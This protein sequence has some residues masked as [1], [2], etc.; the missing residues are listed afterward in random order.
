MLTVL[1]AFAAITYMPV[2]GPALALSCTSVFRCLRQ[3]LQTSPSSG[4]EGGDSMAVA[5]PPGLA[6]AAS[7]VVVN[8]VGGVGDWTIG[9]S[10]EYIVATVAVGRMFLPREMRVPLR[11]TFPIV[12]HGPCMARSMV[13]LRSVAVTLPVA[14][15]CPCSEGKWSI[16]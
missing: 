8:L 9:T 6:D 1:V 16:W 15:A 3:T 7:V 2:T 14:D 5:G 12:G 13:V 11:N 4:G 10:V